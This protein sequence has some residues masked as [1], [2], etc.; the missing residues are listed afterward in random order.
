MKNQ[1]SM[2]DLCAR[3]LVITVPA[4]ILVSAARADGESRHIG[5]Q[6]LA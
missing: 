3:L 5:H 2:H 1:H 4:L 6:H